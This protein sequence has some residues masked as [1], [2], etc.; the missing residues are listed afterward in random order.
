MFNKWEHIDV[1][2]DKCYRESIFNYESPIN[3]W[4]TKSQEAFEEQIEKQV[5]K[6]IINVDVKV[7][8]EE[9]LKALKYDREQYEKG[10]KDGAN[11]II[12]KLRRIILGEEQ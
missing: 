2:L 7:D 6:E 9:L 1:E 10:F 3:I 4:I 11:S 8:K 5:Y 12:E